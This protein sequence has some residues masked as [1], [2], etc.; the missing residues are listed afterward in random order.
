VLAAIPTVGARIISALVNFYLNKKLV[1]HSK[2]TTWKA[3]LRYCCVAIPTL[4]LQMGL[5]WGVCALFQVP[6]DR[7]G[8][9]TLIH[10]CIMT[11]LFIANYIVQQRWVF[12]P[13]NTVKKEG[14]HEQ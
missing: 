1:F 6:E 13:K 2:M 9:R 4:L 8:L 3:L 5:N 10:I 12:L 7:T 11:V 14:K